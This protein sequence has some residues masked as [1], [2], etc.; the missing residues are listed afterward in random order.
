[1]L[2]VIIAVI[3]L[4]AIVHSIPYE[5]CKSNG[6]GAVPIW[7]TVERCE[8]ETDDC[9]FYEGDRVISAEFVRAPNYGTHNLTARLV[10]SMI[11]ITYE[12]PL[13]D[14][15]LD[16]CQH[17]EGASCPLYGG[18]DAIYRFNE[19]MD[20]FLMGGKVWLEHSVMDDFGINYACARFQVTVKKGPRPEE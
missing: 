13:P 6:G 10:A 5:Q 17:I 19:T 7:L 4:T 11:G 20:G 15:A 3:A 12:F 14:N 9:T 18:E 8:L 2:K 1:M 16:A